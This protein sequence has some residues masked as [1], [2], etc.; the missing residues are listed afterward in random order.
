MTV[1]FV[2]LCLVHNVLSVKLDLKIGLDIFFVFQR[3]SH[4]WTSLITELI[5]CYSKNVFERC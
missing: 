4:F 5:L 2:S 3:M 1:V